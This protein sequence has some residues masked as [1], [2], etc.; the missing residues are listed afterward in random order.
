[1]IIKSKLKKFKQLNPK[2]IKS[3]EPEPIKDKKCL[4]F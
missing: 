3:G 4:N 1:M 2:E